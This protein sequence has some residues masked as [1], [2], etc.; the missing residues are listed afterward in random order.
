[1]VNYSYVEKLKQVHDKLD[2]FHTYQDA[3]PYFQK[4]YNLLEQ[5]FRFSI[6]HDKLAQEDLRRICKN[7]S[8]STLEAENYCAFYMEALLNEYAEETG[9]W[10][11]EYFQAHKLQGIYS[12]YIEQYWTK[13]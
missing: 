4:E 11:S 7:I 2:L 9:I 1:M 5:A 13:T 10:P 6:E 3:E 12:T 8:N